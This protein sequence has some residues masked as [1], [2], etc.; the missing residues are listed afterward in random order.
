MLRRILEEV[1]RFGE[2]ALQVTRGAEMVCFV[3]LG[4]LAAGFLLSFVRLLLKKRPAQSQDLAFAMDKNRGVVA[5]FC[6]YAKIVAILSAAVAVLDYT[7][8][9]TV[10]F[11]PAAALVFTGAELVAVLIFEGALL[12]FCHRK[13]KNLRFLYKV[14]RAGEE[15]H[16]QSLRSALK[17]AALSRGGGNGANCGAPDMAPDRFRE[18]RSAASGGTYIKEGQGAADCRVYNKEGSGAAPRDSFCGEARSAVP[19]RGYDGAGRVAMS[20]SA[21]GGAGQ[22]H[23]SG[24]PYAAGGSPEK[25]APENA[26]SVSI[27]S[28]QEMPIDPLSVAARYWSCD[29]ENTVGLPESPAAGTRQGMGQEA[30]AVQD[31]RSVR[32]VAPDMRREEPKT[33]C[34]M[35]EPQFAHHAA[36]AIVRDPI[37]S[38]VPGVPSPGVTVPGI[39]GV[40]PAD[41][42]DRGLPGSVPAGVPAQPVTEPGVA[43]APVT[44]PKT[45][46]EI[47]GDIPQTETVKPAEVSAARFADVPSPVFY[48]AAISGEKVEELLRRAGN[49]PLSETDAFHV[50]KIELS[51][52]DAM[53][54]GCPA[55]TMS[56]LLSALVK[57]IARYEA[58]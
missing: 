29:G 3:L 28:A 10:F 38:P 8:A 30:L 13:N 21:C 9:K 40:A 37:R 35:A 18:E 27:T 45:G 26:V 20:G 23:V 43:P 41:V 14:A 36:E 56:S 2:N 50:K 51:L 24:S 55:D 7:G 47:R 31:G 17:T 25:S 42:P 49:L 33:G 4:L 1:L 57:V 19:G 58:A 32:Q 44:E 39:P 53:C 12:L 11:S 15:R 54:S 22:P 34:H 16:L 48:G 46:A 6:T 52:R 5:G